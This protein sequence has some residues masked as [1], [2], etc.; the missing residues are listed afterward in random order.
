MIRSSTPLSFSGLLQDFFCQ[1]L[2]NQRNLSPQTVAA[3]RDTF[4]LLLAFLQVHRKKSAADFQMVDLDAPSILAFLDHLE[5]DRHNAI[6]SRNAR[7]AA[8]RC[9]FNYAVAREPTCLPMVQRILAI[10]CKRFDRPLVGF[11]SAQEVQTIL[12]APDPNTFSGQRDRVLLALLYNTGARVSEV[13]GLKVADLTLAASSSLQLHGKGRK[14]RCVP[15][16]PSTARQLRGWLKC[17]TASPD[18]PLLPNAAGT[19]MTRSGIAKRLACASASAARKMPALQGRRISPHTFRHT[20]AMHLLQAGVDVNMI[21]LWLGHASPTTTHEYVE[22]DL[23]MKEQALGKLQQPRSRR[24]CYRPSD[25]LLR[26]LEG[27]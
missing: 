22:A 5:H 14:Q 3:Y 13:A 19:F 6:R 25:S 21:A 10:P 4:R 18:A 12:E 24:V 15:L 9:F 23:K 17:I 11:L 27:L 7:L 2:M 1:Y 8:I 16:W 26:F 20:T